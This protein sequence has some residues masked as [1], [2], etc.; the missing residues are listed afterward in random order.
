MTL[1]LSSMK[2]VGPVV[3]E[4]DSLLQMLVMKIKT[5]VDHNFIAVYFKCSMVLTGW[6]SC[7]FGCLSE[8]VSSCC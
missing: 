7:K 5:D 3:M 6:Y 8:G 4:K 1:W 2:S